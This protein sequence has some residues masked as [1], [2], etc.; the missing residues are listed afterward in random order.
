MKISGFPGLQWTVVGFADD[1]L[2]DTQDNTRMRLSGPILTPAQI[3]NPVYSVFSSAGPLPVTLAPGAGGGTVTRARR[4]LAG[5][6]LH[7]SAS[8]S[9]SAA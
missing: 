8:A 4:R 7:R 5:R 9:R 2:T 1:D 3:A 6:R